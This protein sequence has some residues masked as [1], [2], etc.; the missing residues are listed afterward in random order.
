MTQVSTIA[1][2][3]EDDGAS[4][5]N[6]L[7]TP[8]TKVSGLTTKLSGIAE[9][10]RQNVAAA[11]RLNPPGPLRDENR[12]LVQALQLRVSGVA[13]LAKTFSATASKSSGDAALLDR[14]GRAAAR[15][16]CRLGR[17]LQGPPT[18]VMSAKGVSGVVA[19]DSNFV[20]NEDF[21]TEHSMGSC[22]SG[23]AARRPAGRRAACTARTSSPRRRT[24]AARSRSV[25]P[26]NTVTASADLAFVVTVHDGGDSQEVGIKVTLTIGKPGGAI[27]KTKTIKVFNPGQDATVTF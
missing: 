26:E 15:E 19:P 27:V 7:T 23:S 9:Q 12:A 5:A 1:H 6:A 11:Q 20:A 16:R 3:S 25:T 13:G 8:G 21:I 18:A 4:V 24:P 17:L 14:P 22:S 2:S 10:E